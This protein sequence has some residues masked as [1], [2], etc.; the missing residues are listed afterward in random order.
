LEEESINLEG[1]QEKAH[2]LTFNT[3]SERKEARKREGLECSIKVNT[4]VPR[5]VLTQ[6]NRR[7]HPVDQAELEK[8]RSGTEEASRRR[9]SKLGRFVKGHNNTQPKLQRRAPHR[10]VTKARPRKIDIQY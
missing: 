6:T 3:V 10:T 7:Y 4:A 9:H 8:E 5:K 1:G 2:P